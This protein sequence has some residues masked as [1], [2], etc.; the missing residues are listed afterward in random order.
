VVEGHILRLI[1]RKS[2]AGIRG[3]SSVEPFII[4]SLEL[5]AK[6]CIR[7]IQEFQPE[8]FEVIF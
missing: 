7:R 6:R 5:C 2:A 8:P 3:E 4:T 1:P